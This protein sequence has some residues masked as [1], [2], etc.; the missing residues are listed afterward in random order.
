MRAAGVFASLYALHAS[1]A[2]GSLHLYPELDLGETE[3]L[4]QMLSNS[5]GLWGGDRHTGNCGAREGL[6]PNT[7]IVVMLLRPHGQGHHHIAVTMGI[8]GLSISTRQSLDRLIRGQSC[9][10]CGEPLGWT[11]WT[12]PT[13]E[14]G[15]RVCATCDDHEREVIAAESPDAVL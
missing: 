8:Q 3:E 5:I 9:A 12:F 11:Q 7:T 6:S 13:P 15:K 14:S 2:T 1:G 10:D 4:V